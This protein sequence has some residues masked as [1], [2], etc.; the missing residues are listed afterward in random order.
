MS[1]ELTAL[2]ELV[3]MLDELHSAAGR[4]SQRTIGDGAGVG[5]ATVHGLLHG[6]HLPSWEL[7]A[8]VVGYRHGALDKALAL[9]Q[10][11]DSDK[12]NA[13]AARRPVFTADREAEAISVT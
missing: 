8:A 7:T 5:T 1:S 2:D 11:A 6:A 12:K 3:R 13:R 4:P 9:W 10:Q